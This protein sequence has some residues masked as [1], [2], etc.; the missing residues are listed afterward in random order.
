V[1][2]RGHNQR[3]NSGAERE[4]AAPVTARG[5]VERSLAC[6]HPK[7]EADCREGFCR[8]EPG[9]FVMGAPR[10]EWGSGRYCDRQVE[11]TLTRAFWIGQTEVTRRQWASVGW[12]A[13]KQRQLN[14]TAECV[15]PDCPVGNVSFLDA[16][17]Y[18]NVYSEQRGLP[19][20]YEMAGCR[21][22][23]GDGLRCWSVAFAP[24][25][26]Y[27][28]EGYRLPTEAEWEY[29]ARAG[30]DTAFFSGGIGPRADGGCYAEPD[31]DRIGWYCWNSAGASRKVAQKEP[32]GWGLYDT[33]GNVSEWC[34]DI[35]FG[36]GYGEGPLV[37]PV[38][39]VALGGDLMRER[40]HFRVKRGG[41]H[42]RPAYGC[43]ASFRS[44]MADTGFGSNAGFRLARTAAD[45]SGERRRKW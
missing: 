10:D 39:V 29:A 35:Y 38:G 4:A 28:C 25:D 3:A 37:D 24:R 45:A 36:F 43:K 31:L 34:D 2:A 17:A 40:R 42:R 6:R 5:S 21:G 15:E 18:A 44:Y 1:L 32:N 13:P 22:D 8:I 20:C 23:V 9:C 26:I 33:S 27:E 12:D 30:T 41:S 11:V 19:A 14:G 16:V 7:V